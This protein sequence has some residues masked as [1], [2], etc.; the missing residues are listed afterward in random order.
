MIAGSVD[1]L[2]LDD[3]T[4]IVFEAFETGCRRVYGVDIRSKRT[5]FNAKTLRQVQSFAKEFGADD[6]VRIINRLF[7]E[8]YNGKAN[9][10]T[11]GASIFARGFRWLANQLLLESGEGGDM[12]WT[13]F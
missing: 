9:G 11:I 4:R 13:K 10:K 5:I 6:G 2:L 8:P 12:L 1:A 3:D 7:M